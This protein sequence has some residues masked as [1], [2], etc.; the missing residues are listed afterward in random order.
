[1]IGLKPFVLIQRKGARCPQWEEVVGLPKVPHLCP[2]NLLR[3]YVSLTHTCVPQGASLLC[4]LHA[5]FLP[6]KANSI[7]SLTRKA[8]AQLGVNTNVWKPHSTRGAGVAMLKSLGLSSEEV[9][10]IGKWKNVGAF[11][12]HYLRLNAATKVGEKLQEMFVHNVSPLDSAEPELTRTT[13]KND[14]G[15]SVREGGAQDNGETRFCR[16]L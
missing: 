8:L 12:S 7:G 5:P 16:R 6:L 13:G 9:C 10:E 2:F 15:G 4:C 14:P 1:M 11:T 3:R